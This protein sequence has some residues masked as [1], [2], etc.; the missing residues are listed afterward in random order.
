M[1][2]NNHTIQ[3]IVLQDI[4][5]LQIEQRY[6][7]RNVIGTKNKLVFDK[8]SLVISILLFVVSLFPLTW[9]GPSTD[10]YRNGGSGLFEFLYFLLFFLLGLMGLVNGQK[11]IE[12]KKYGNHKQKRIKY[13]FTDGKYKRWEFDKEYDTEYLNLLET[14]QTKPVL[15]GTRSDLNIKYWLYQDKIWKENEEYNANEVKTLVD[16][17]LEKKKV[18]LEKAEKAKERRESPEIKE[19][20]SRSRRISQEVKDKVWNRDDGK[21][22]QCGSNKDLE[23]DHIIP[24]SK[25]GANTYRNLQLLCE[26]CNRS[27]SDKIG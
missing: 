9:D 18:R 20:D 8:E 15:F 7:G 5:P 12:V 1:I 4:G 25:G 27:K 21:C 19:G 23:F 24:F 22:V 6:V 3:S 17:K 14:Q 26:Y 13:Y 2:Y 11:T 10:L 16:E